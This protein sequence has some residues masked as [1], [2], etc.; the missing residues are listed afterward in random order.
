MNHAEGSLEALIQKSLDCNKLN[1]PKNKRKA[2]QKANW[3]SRQEG[4]CR[5]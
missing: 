5:R 1:K 3:A 4:R 2:E